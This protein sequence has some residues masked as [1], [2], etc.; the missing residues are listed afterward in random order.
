MIWFGHTVQDFFGT[1]R[2]KKKKKEKKEYAYFIDKY[3]QRVIN[4]GI[5]INTLEL[6]EQT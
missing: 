4:S 1:V 6:E 5:H 2:N 3:K